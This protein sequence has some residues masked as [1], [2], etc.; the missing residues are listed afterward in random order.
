MYTF[1]IASLQVADEGLTFYEVLENVPTDP[2]SV[3][4]YLLVA[5]GL[6]VI[7]WSNR[8][9]RRKGGHAG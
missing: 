6:G 5:V 1:V 4:V 7:A 3:F 8:P 9:R 2:A